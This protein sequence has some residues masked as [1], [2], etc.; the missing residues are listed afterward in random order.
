MIVLVREGMSWS[1][2]E[3]LGQGGNV[4]V[5]E[6]MSWSGRECLGQGGNVLVFF[7]CPKND[8]DYHV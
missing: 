6:G 1:G 8:D 7:Y 5:R 3:C 2:R 4:L